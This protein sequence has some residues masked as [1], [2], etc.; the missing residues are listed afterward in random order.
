LRYPCPAGGQDFYLAFPKGRT[1]DLATF[2]NQNVAIRGSL[3]A[4]TCSLPLM[5]V[6]R[7]AISAIVPPCVDPG[8]PVP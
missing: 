7:I 3:H 2:E 6:S 1:A 5:Q 8:E 4:T